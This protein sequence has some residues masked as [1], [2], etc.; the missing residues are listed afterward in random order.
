MFKYVQGYITQD[1]K[2]EAGQ[3]ARSVVEPKKVF[4]LTDMGRVQKSGVAVREAINDRDSSVVDDVAYQKVINSSEQHPGILPPFKIDNCQYILFASMGSLESFQLNYQQSRIAF[5]QIINAI[6]H[7]HEQLKVVH[8]DIK[9]RNIDMLDNGSLALI[10]FDGVRDI[11]NF[12]V[13]NTKMMQTPLYIP[14]ELYFYDDEAWVKM[15]SPEEKYRMCDIWALGMTMFRVLA[16]TVFENISNELF[17]TYGIIKTEKL[18]EFFSGLHNYIDQ[19][20]LKSVKQVLK[21]LLSQDPKERLNNFNQIQNCQFFQDIEIQLAFEFSLVPIAKLPEKEGE[22]KQYVHNLGKK[23]SELKALPEHEQNKQTQYSLIV[24]RHYRNKALT[25]LAKIQV[26]KN[27]AY[28]SRL[29]RFYIPN[30]SAW[31]Q[32]LK[33]VDR[34][35]LQRLA[36]HKKVTAA[37]SAYHG[38]KDDEKPAALSRLSIVLQTANQADPA[39]RKII[40]RVEVVKAWNKLDA[41]FADSHDLKLMMESSHELGHDFQV[42]QKANNKQQKY[43]AFLKIKNTVSAMANDDKLPEIARFKEQLKDPEL[44]RLNGPTE[45]PTLAEWQKMSKCYWLGLFARARSSVTRE[46]D[47]SIALFYE[48]NNDKEKMALAMK[49]IRNANRYLEVSTSKS[50]RVDAVTDLLQRSINYVEAQLTI[51]PDW[52]APSVE[53]MASQPKLNT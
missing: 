50:A 22:L 1:V 21:L 51:H 45:I 10:D 35:L 7:M 14:P 28:Q 27:G 12:D 25:Q 4:M 32:L 40:D 38:A 6:K 20:E 39:V 46:L 36:S 37:L 49:I 8:L 53:L 19:I 34:S 30:S 43:Q 9:E 18:E 47:K 41:F 16:P 13:A 2:R 5:A 29:D 33:T 31:V 42:F 11:E 24:H 26:Q 52:R 15:M 23:I 44:S 3:G 48:A 17:S